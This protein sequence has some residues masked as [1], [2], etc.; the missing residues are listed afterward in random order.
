MKHCCSTA[1]DADL[2]MYVFDGDSLPT[3]IREHMSSCSDCQQRMQRYVEIHSRL[4]TRLFRYE[5]PTMLTISQYC[6]DMLSSADTIWVARHVEVCPLCAD[7]VAVTRCELTKAYISLA[8]FYTQ[9]AGCEDS[10]IL[11]QD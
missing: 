8:S 9:T 2:L 11:L 3:P 10:D 7:E 4:L 6:A 5:C 1:P